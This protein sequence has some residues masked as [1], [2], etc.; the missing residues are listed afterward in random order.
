MTDPTIAEAVAKAQEGRALVKAEA[1]DQALA[2]L[3]LD[4]RKSSAAA[5]VHVLCTSPCGTDDMG[6]PKYLSIPQARVLAWSCFEDGLNPVKNEAWINPKTGN[7]AYTVEGQRKIAR[8]Q[9]R[10][11][12]P[13]QKT[14]VDRDFGS[15]PV[16]TE[17]RSQVAKLKAAGFDRDYGCTCEI[18]VIGFKRPARYT[19][20]LS[21]WYMPSNPNWKARTQHMLGV[22][23]EGHC[24]ETIT[25]VG[26]SSDILKD[27]A[28]EA[29]GEALA[30]QIETTPGKFISLPP[31]SRE[32]G[33]V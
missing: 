30:P 19:A 3:D 6:N 15:V 28:A 18:E 13:P 29:A 23:A 9:G 16:S 14:P 12:G 21:E 10:Q 4:W 27:E 32:G 1:V 11:L 24:L 7:V 5:V 31:P 17:S 25:G 20:W 33:E 22:R 26:V 8:N 2:G